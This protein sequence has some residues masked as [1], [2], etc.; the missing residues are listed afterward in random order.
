VARRNPSTTDGSAVAAAPSPLTLALGT[1]RRLAG[2][3]PLHLALIGLMVLWSIPTIALLVSSFREATAIASSG[4]WNAIKAP[5]D[6][7]VENYRTVLEKQG[8][9][10]AF[11]N[12]V[13]ITVPS[14]MLVIL[15]AAWA[16]YAFA[17]MRFPARNLLFLLMVALLV[18]PV[19]MTLIPVLRLYTNLTVDAELPILG[20]RVFGTSSFVGIWVAHTAYGLPFAIYLLRNFFGSLPRD[21]F[22]SAYLDGASDL[23]VF[24]RIVLPLSLPAISALAIFQF[25]WVWN[26]L[27]VALIFLGDPNLAPMTVKVTNLVSSFGTNYQV[28]TAAAFVS[29]ALP[30][31]I[32]FAL[33]RYF[34][35]GVLAGAVKG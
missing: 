22:E 34:V 5:L 11:F 31:V 10:R 25:L 7:T 17:W 35:E 21:L 26:D 6:L 32:F 14:T 15:V 30:L 9:A 33:Q 23:G 16:A 13:I 19:Q 27:L 1:A 29:M 2:R 28:L 8:M 18:V 4:W 20:G 12:S 3:V 24:F